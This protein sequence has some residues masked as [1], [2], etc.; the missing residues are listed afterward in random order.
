M[1]AALLVSPPP[2]PPNH[3]PYACIQVASHKTVV[4]FDLLTLCQHHAA[5]LDACL[6]PLLS[7]GALLKL[8]FEVAGD[9]SKL[10]SSWPSVPAFRVVAGVLDL[11]PLFV[12]YGLAARLQVCGGSCGRGADRQA[13]HG[14]ARLRVRGM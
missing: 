8:G 5:A 6:S 1:F 4:L 7:D 13:G 2:P 9:L 10:A 12:A 11:R 14:F 3:Q